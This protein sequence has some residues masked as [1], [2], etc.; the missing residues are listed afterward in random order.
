MKICVLSLDRNSI[1]I[2][3]E[4]IIAKH[5]QLMGLHGHDVTL[6]VPRCM[7]VHEM[8]ADEVKVL[9]PPKWLSLLS[10]RGGF[11]FGDLVFRCWIVLSRKFDVIHAMAG[12]HRPIQLIP[13]LAGRIFRSSLLIDE[14]W[15]W[16]GGEG[17][18]STRSH[19]VQK[20]IGGY[21][22]FFE[23]RSKK[24]FNGIIAITSE[25][26]NR[27]SS[28]RKCLVL[29]G[30]TDRDIFKPYELQEA[31]KAVQ[32]KPADFIIGMSNLSPD[33]HDENYPFLCAMLEAMKTAPRLKL[34][35]T[36]PKDYI[37]SI[38][39]PMFPEER[40]ISLG[41]LSLEKYNAYLSACNAFALPFSD[42]AR[43]RGR[44]PN[45]I[46]D[47]I[48]LQRPVITNPTGDVKGLLEEYLVG[49]LVPSDMESYL[50]ALQSI[51]ARDFLSSSFQSALDDI[52]D[53]D[54]R[55]RRILDYY[56]EV[57]K[58]DKSKRNT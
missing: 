53:F 58:C 50:Q 24:A 12:G 57:M 4:R 51:H 27:L 32:L 6:I 35:L 16:I 18:A 34:L 13:A 21:D 56:D 20:I 28:K 17:I 30:A 7:E 19:G 41:W 10:C 5:A 2:A 55:V 39:K 42:T 40:V 1:G 22:T 37:D 38:I 43:N 11:G 29:H 8:I 45:K 44:W 47:Y 25:L 3:A 36:G 15:E 48:C 14:W 31:R 26:R 54:G 23:L 33:D 9:D 46:G 52:P 49:V